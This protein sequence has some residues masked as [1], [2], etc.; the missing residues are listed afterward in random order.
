[1]LLATWLTTLIQMEPGNQQHQQHAEICQAFQP[2]ETWWNI[3][4]H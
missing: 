2:G 3:V 4:K 1:M